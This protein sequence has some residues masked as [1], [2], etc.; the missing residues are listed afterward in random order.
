[1][2]LGLTF[3]LVNFFL[4]KV[5]FA[6]NSFENTANCMAELGAATVVDKIIV[7]NYLAN[8]PRD[9]E[10]V[11]FLKMRV[12]G[13][14]AAHILYQSS[15]SNWSADENNAIRLKMQN[16]IAKNYEGKSGEDF[17]KNSQIRTKACLNQLG[18][19]AVEDMLNKMLSNERWIQILPEYMK[20]NF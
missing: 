6:S 18:A 4:L 3:F 17:L 12:A 8:N 5:S 13:Y 15:K 19:K 20:I 9:R 1:M 11:N 7:R 16:I 2:R 14:Q 10:Q